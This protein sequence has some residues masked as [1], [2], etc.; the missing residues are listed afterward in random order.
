MRLLEALHKNEDSCFPVLEEDWV[1]CLFRLDQSEIKTYQ[2]IFRFSSNA[3][4]LLGVV[5][6]WE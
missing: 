4:T 6:W 5:E 2:N 1:R 3:A